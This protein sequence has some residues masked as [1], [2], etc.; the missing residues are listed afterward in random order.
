MQ[1]RT[2]I[3]VSEAQTLEGPWSQGVRVGQLVFTSGQVPV[4]PR[5]EEVVEGGVQ[6][7]VRQSLSN[8]ETILESSGASLADVVKVTVY[9]A[10]YSDFDAV[11]EAYGKFFGPNYP[12][13][14]LITARELPV[15]N[16]RS[17]RVI[18]EAIAYIPH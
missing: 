5:T 15:L 1:D 7:Q 2:F 9:L 6:E 13:R 11:N 3:N 17:V 10:D 16:G 4:N 12:A 14:T 18:I 8:V